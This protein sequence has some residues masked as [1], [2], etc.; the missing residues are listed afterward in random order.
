[1]GYPTGYSIPLLPWNGIG[2]GPGGGYHTMKRYGIAHGPSG[3]L[4][5]MRLAYCI[6]RLSLP[7]VLY[8]IPYL[9]KWYWYGISDL[10]PILYRG[11]GP[12]P[13]IPYHPISFRPLI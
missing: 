6:C 1:M 7:L 11:M 2:M 4:S 9:L 12:Y 10:D 13:Y 5:P 3:K 8:N